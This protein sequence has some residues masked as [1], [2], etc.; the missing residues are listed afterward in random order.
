M[1]AGRPLLLRVFVLIA[2][3]AVGLLSLQV[4]RPLAM[5][6]MMLPVLGA[7]SDVQPFSPV[8]LVIPSN[9]RATNVELQDALTRIA[10]DRKPCERL[11]DARLLGALYLLNAQ[12][13]EAYKALNCVASPDV[14]SSYFEAIACTSRIR[15]C[16]SAP[17][18]AAILRQAG[19]NLWVNERYVDALGR[20]AVAEQVDPGS[21]PDKALA[22][23]LL[24]V[25]AA[26]V[27][28]NQEQ[29]IHWSLLWSE[30]A[31]ADLDA[32]FTLCREYLAA[33]QTS[34]ALDALGQAEPHGARHNWQFGFLMG[35][36][37]SARG[38]IAQAIE[39]YRVSLSLNPTEPTVAWN[40]AT[41]LIAIGRGDEALTYLTYV[42]NLDQAVPYQASLAD[43]AKVELQ[44][45]IR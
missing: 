5:N 41:A 23:R 38:N 10:G 34:A 1:R 37:L 26:T 42:A 25:G 36:I 22:Y 44:K 33:G 30:S 13:G 15:P 24:S 4:S 6:A 7:I 43:A 19:I 21:R 39:M 27:L 45:L 16:R 32:Y 12:P 31:P 17:Q 18:L 8:E 14:L 29:A 9:Q 28:H 40:L 3:A 35:Q 11:Q 20:L 2:V